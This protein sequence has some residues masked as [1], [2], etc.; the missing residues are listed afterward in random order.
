M[1]NWK[2]TYEATSTG[3]SAYVSD[4]PGCIAIGS[5]LNETRDRMKDAILAH[6]EL[7][8]AEGDPTPEHYC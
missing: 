2:I 8:C 6:L 1:E 5:T 7:L 4:L 3:W